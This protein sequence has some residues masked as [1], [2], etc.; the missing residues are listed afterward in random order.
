M[1]SQVPETKGW[2]SLV[3]YISR[4]SCF[5]ALD[6]WSAVPGVRPAQLGE[7]RDKWKELH[8]KGQ[9]VFQGRAKI[10]RETY[11]EKSLSTAWDSFWA[12][13]VAAL[14]SPTCGGGGQ[15]V[16]NLRGWKNSRKPLQVLIR[17]GWGNPTWLE[18]SSG[19]LGSSK[20]HL[21][22]LDGGY[23]SSEQCAKP[24]RRSIMLI[25]NRD[26]HNGSL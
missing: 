8:W 23:Y 6:S 15:L 12:W 2:E 17:E 1:C 26:P 5:V 13:S 3:S 24:K 18:T 14:T 11:L 21:P 7:K 22:E 10:C 4:C 20:L 9:R 16:E 25:G 19:K